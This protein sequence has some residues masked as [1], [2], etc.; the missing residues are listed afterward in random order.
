M[1]LPTVAELAP[2]LALFRAEGVAR[3]ATPE[4]TIDMGIERVP[5]RASAIGGEVAPV[6][7]APTT[8][9]PPVHPILADAIVAAMTAD[10]DEPTP[11]EAADVEAFRKWQRGDA[12]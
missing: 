9:A 1:P 11:E 5:R 2:L 7:A 8:P 3:F 6:S 10:D 4:L 12:A